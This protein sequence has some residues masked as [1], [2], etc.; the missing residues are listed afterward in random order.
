MQHNFFAKPYGEIPRVAD[1]H[2]TQLYTL[3]WRI[4]TASWNTP[5][6]GSTGRT[7]L[8]LSLQ[9]G[10]SLSHCGFDGMRAGL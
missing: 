1:Y 6:P 5:I 4:F 8:A 7:P 10:W 9:G 2:S 3:T